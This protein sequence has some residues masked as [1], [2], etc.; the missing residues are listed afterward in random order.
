MRDVGGVPVEREKVSGDKLKGGRQEGVAGRKE[1]HIHRPTSLR[2]ISSRNKQTYGGDDKYEGEGESEGTCEC[3]SRRNLQFAK[4][5]QP[6]ISTHTETE[7]EQQ[8][9]SLTRYHKNYCFLRVRDS[10]RVSL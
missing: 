8:Q 2:T 5:L 6:L 3:D 1:L 4:L 9:H 10:P 7:C